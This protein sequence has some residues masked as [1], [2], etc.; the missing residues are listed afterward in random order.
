MLQEPKGFWEVVGFEPYYYG[1]M[2]LTTATFGTEGAA[3]EFAKQRGGE[4]KHREA[5]FIM[6]DGKVIWERA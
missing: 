6:E 3:R 5:D 2:Y 1:N 4:V